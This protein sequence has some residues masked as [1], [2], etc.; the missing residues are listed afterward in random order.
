MAKC[1]GL[2][3][4]LSWWLPKPLAGLHIWSLV[5]CIRCTTDELNFCLERCLSRWYVSMSQRSEGTSVSMPLSN[6]VAHCCCSRILSHLKQFLWGLSSMRFGELS[7]LAKKR[8]LPPPPPLHGFRSC[9]CHEFA[10]VGFSNAVLAP[11]SCLGNVSIAGLPDRVGVKI[12]Q[13]C[14]QSAQSTFE[15]TC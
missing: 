12:V 8:N 15:F 9:F 5:A 3:A 7:A 6:R 10:Q 14:V 4:D 2:S 13:S 11:T 1:W